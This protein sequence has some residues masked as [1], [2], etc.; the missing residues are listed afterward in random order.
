MIVNDQKVVVTMQ[1][2]T[3]LL[4]Q[5]FI[6]VSEPGLNGR[7]CGQTRGT[8][9]RGNKKVLGPNAMTVAG[10]PNYHISYIA[11]VSLLGLLQE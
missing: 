3:A 10:S 8:A 4:R 1:K 9:V 6:I 2:L 5:N 11:L 7:L